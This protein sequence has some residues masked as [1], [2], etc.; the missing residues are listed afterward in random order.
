MQTLWDL[1]WNLHLKLLIKI[2]RTVTKTALYPQVFIL[3]SDTPLHYNFS[4]RSQ[5]KSLGNC[6]KYTIKLDHHVGLCK[7]VKFS[8]LK[9]GI[10]HFYFYSMMV[11][12][13]WSSKENVLFIAAYCQHTWARLYPTASR[14]QH[15]KWKLNQVESKHKK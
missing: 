4:A 6:L 13:P 12:L 1:S 11:C 9:K 10:L 15:T 5:N 8:E 2:S 3:F 14:L 7:D